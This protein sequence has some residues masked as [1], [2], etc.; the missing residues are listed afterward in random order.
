MSLSHDCVSRGVIAQEASRVRTPFSGDSAFKLRWRGAD[1]VHMDVTS[2]QFAILDAPL[3]EAGVV[4]E[5]RGELDIATAPLLRAHLTA[6]VESGPGLLVVD[7]TRV[8]FLDSITLAVLLSTRKAL[9]D[10]GRMAVVVEPDSYTRLI[11]DIAGVD[12]WLHV[13]AT[14][15]DAI[16]NR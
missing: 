16:A 4:V 5:V 8:D 2:T 15:D 10:A 6:V 12:Q 9:G 1:Y 11:F 13:V 3:G 7:L 14:R